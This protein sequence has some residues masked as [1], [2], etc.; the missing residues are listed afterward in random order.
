SDSDTRAYRAWVVFYAA[1]ALAIQRNDSRAACAMASME[2]ANF[3]VL[4][5]SDR[6]VGAADEFWDAGDWRS[7]PGGG[8]HVVWGVLSRGTGEGGLAYP[9]EGSGLAPRVDDSRVCRGVGGCN[10]TADH[11]DIFCHQPGLG[12]NA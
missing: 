4:R 6:R 12:F 10:D 11:R 7:Q 2:R 9:K 1:G 3:C 5:S 8:D